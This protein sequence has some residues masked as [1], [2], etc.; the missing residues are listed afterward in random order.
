MQALTAYTEFQERATRTGTMR[1]LARRIRGENT[2]RRYHAEQD[3]LPG[4]NDPTDTAIR[5][6]LRRNRVSA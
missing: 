2:L 4:R 5:A 1:A 6:A 3:Q